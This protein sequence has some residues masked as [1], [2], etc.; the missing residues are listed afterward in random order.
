MNAFSFRP[1]TTSPGLS[2]GVRIT[3]KFGTDKLQPSWLNALVT[4]V[5]R[6]FTVA[7]VTF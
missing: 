1:F 5:L 7:S 2:P 4:P 6:G 3:L